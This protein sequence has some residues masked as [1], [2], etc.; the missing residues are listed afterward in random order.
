MVRNFTSEEEIQMLSKLL[1]EA[2]QRKDNVATD[3]NAEYSG[4]PFNIQTFNAISP[5]GLEKY[6]TGKYKVSGD[7]DALEGGPHAIMLRSHKLQVE[8]ITPSVRAIA[9]CGAGTNNIPVDKMSE[10]GIPVFNTP[11]AN[12]GAVKELVVCGL[13]LGSRGIAEGI[14]HVQNNIIPEEAGDYSKINARIEKDK[15]MF[16]GQEIAGKT[17]GVIGLG[18]IGSRVVGAALSLGMK[19]VGYDPALS[20]EAAW[21]LPGEQMTRAKTLEDLF[22]RSDYISLHV[23]YIKEHTHHLIDE[24]A[25]QVMKP[26]CSILNFARGEIVDGNALRAAYESGNFN[27]RY[28]SDFADKDLMGHPN[29]IVMP[30][31]G[32]STAEAEENSAAM[33]AEQIIDF[34]ET[35][36]IKNSVNFPNCSLTPKDNKSSRLCI[37]N[38]NHPGV[39]GSITTFL[40]EKGINITQ[41]INHSRDNLAY[42]VVDMDGQPD[43]PSQLQEELAKVEGIMSSRFIGVPFSNELGR[44]G[45]YY[46]VSWYL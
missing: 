9:R 3:T 1:D 40:G 23:P 14:A 43:D 46:H 22:S 4:Q 19:V 36:S 6:P 17:L 37:V 5:V 18:H 13:L 30:H 31:L 35:G 26:K 11:G 16:V 33:A 27:G 32:A 44:P 8:E 45:T 28:I 29:H 10:M 24:K 7:V 2:K 34:L 42:T 41:Q 12:A 38:E 15:K 25:L 20:L 39:L 21:R